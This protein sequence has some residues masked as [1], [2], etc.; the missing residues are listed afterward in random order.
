MWEAITK[1]IK[2]KNNINAIVL[3]NFDH[4][5]ISKD[6]TN[7]LNDSNLNKFLIKQEIRKKQKYKL[8]EITGVPVIKT[9]KLIENPYFNIIND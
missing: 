5:T 4:Y 2:I 8:S 1:S 6:F 9:L 7:N 3:S